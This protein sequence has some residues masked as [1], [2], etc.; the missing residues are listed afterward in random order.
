MTTEGSM[1]PTLGQPCIFHVTG[2]LRYAGQVVHVYADGTVAVH[3]HEKAI[4]NG[5]WITQVNE[6]V[7]WSDPTDAK[8]PCAYAIKT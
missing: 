4:G 2:S 7:P 8:F 3:W 6:D 5:R 1:T